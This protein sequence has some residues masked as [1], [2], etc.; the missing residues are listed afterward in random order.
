MQALITPRAAAAARNVRAARSIVLA[1]RFNTARPSYT[2]ST[3]P[4]QAEAGAFTYKPGGPI[5]RGT[6]NDAVPYPH[7][8]RS[9]GSY[10]WSFE[11]LLCA[12][13]IPLTGATF[14]VS[15]TAHP[16]LDGL[17]AV[18]IIVHSHI[19]FDASLTDYLHPRKFPLIGPLMKWLVR[20]MTAGALVGLY[21][22]NTNDIGL[23]EFIKR[24]WHA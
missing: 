3:Q 23:T 22:F 7:P 21:Q 4:K 8:S 10:H 13:L 14:V 15:G 17:L 18:S 24:L 6:V 19:G 9:H 11:R 2:Q 12:A 1:A 16:I 20:G 5:I